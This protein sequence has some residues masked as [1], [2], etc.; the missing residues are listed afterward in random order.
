MPRSCHVKGPSS[1]IN[2]LE[3]RVVFLALKHLLLPLK[4]NHVLS[5]DN[6]I[7]KCRGF[8]CLNHPGVGL[9]A[10]GLIPFIFGRPQ[11]QT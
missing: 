11:F 10:A 5:M 3:M 4:G 7:L 1:L 8:H 6:T 2:C 9:C